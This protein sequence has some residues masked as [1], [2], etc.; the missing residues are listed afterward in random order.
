MMSVLARR[1]T[2][3]GYGVLAIDLRGHGDNHNPLPDTP[4][5]L[6]D[7]VGSAVRYLRRQPMIDPC[8]LY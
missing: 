1:L 6:L 5:P 3:N 4:V 7:D 8:A 2:N